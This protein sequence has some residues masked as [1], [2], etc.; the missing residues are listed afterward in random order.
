MKIWQKILLILGLIMLL[1]GALSYDAYYAAAQRFTPRYETLSSESI[2]AQLDDVTILFFSDLDYGTFMDKA[3]LNKLVNAVNNL[4]PDIVVFGGDLFDAACTPDEETVAEVTEGLRSISHHLGKFAV[5]GDFDHR[6]DEI[7][8]LTQQV[9]YDADFELLYNAS[10]PIR[11][12]GSQSITLIG[13][14]SALKGYP[15]TRSSFA[16]VSKNAYT[17]T[18]CHTPD[19]ADKVPTDL[20]DYFL[21]GHSHGGQ[22]YYGFG[23]W[24]TP[25]GAVNYFRGKHTVDGTFTLDISSGVGTTGQDVRFLANAEIVLYR[26]KHIETANEEN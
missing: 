13:I 25:D 16:N 12:T 4:S 5:L 3:R 1:A 21:A 8:E 9:L 15:N 19:E 24:Y 7:L 18:V 10:I 23:A 17:I 6:N 11:N 2:P 20:V 14:D 26:L 22:I